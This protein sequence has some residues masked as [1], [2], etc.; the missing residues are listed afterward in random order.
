MNAHARSADDTQARLGEVTRSVADFSPYCEVGL[1]ATWTAN[2]KLTATFAAVSGWQLFSISNSAPA[3]GILLDYAAR[4]EFTISYDNFIGNVAPDTESA[5]LR[6][7]HDVVARYNSNDRSKFAA[8]YALGT[9][10]ERASNNV[11]ASW[12]GTTVIVKRCAAKTLVVGRLEHYSDPSQV[13]V[14]PPVPERFRT[15]AASLGIDVNFTGP[16]LWRIE[17]RG[18][19]SRFAV[20]LLNGANHFGGRDRFVV[21]SLALTF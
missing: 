10:R 20:W 8:V 15:R 12:W 2:K 14:V 18:Y 19:R 11:A 7:Y 3:G 21:S 6:V 9:Q 5:R 16:V 17:V 13:I 1:K 4:P